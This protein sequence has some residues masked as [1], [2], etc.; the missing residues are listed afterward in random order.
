[1]PFVRFG[2]RGQVPVTAQRERSTDR[3]TKM[4]QKKSAMLFAVKHKKTQTKT[5]ANTPFRPVIIHSKHKIKAD[6]G[7]K[8][9]SDD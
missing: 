1:M 4:Q 6:T 3:Q 9:K 8:S 5:E 2:V 7:E